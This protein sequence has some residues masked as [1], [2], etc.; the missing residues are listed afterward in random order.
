MGLGSRPK[1]MAGLL[2]AGLCA[3]PA[4]AAERAPTLGLSIDGSASTAFTDNT[5]RNP[6][7]RSDFLTSPYLKLSAAGRLVPNLTYS[8]YASGGF[9]KYATRGDADST[10]AAL[11]A[12]LRRRWGPF[13]IGA[14]YERSRAY[15]GIFGP[16]LYT[17]HDVSASA[18]YNYIGPGT[19]LKIRP[20]MTVAHRS[21]DD[22]SA[23]RFVYSFKVDIEHRLV[24]RWWLTLTPRV[25]FYHFTSSTNAGRQDTLSSISGGLRYSFNDDLSLSA[26]AGYETRTSTKDDKRFDNFGAG[27]SIDFS[28]N[29]D[30]P[31]LRA[32]RNARR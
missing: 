4:G 21:A 10:F 16:F 25:R 28:Y 19:R 2:C 7:G 9:D 20:G 6:Q 29:L 31:W 3:T 22:P 27:A 14:S 30:P 23:Q 1:G 13:H 18:G 12:S 24:E 15:D 32:G 26:T 8:L 11:G 17:A 5:Y